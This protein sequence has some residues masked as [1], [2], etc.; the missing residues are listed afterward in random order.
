M[1]LDSVY[2]CRWCGGACRHINNDQC[3]SGGGGGGG[4]GGGEECPNPE[5]DRVSPKN[6]PLKGNT[7][8][9]IHGKNLGIRFEDIER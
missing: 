9:E 6:A 4:G 1:G 8:V 7:R 2:D 5:I 3:G